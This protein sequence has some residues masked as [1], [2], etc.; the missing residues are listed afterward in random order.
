MTMLLYDLNIDIKLS[1]VYTFLAV[2]KHIQHNKTFTTDKI[3]D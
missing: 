1:I 3:K 2:S